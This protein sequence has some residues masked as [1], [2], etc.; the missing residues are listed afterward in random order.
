MEFS[1]IYQCDFA[2]LMIN[3][4][5]SFVSVKQYKPNGSDQILK[6]KRKI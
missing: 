4:G 1:T 5:A 2:A 6:V 3:N